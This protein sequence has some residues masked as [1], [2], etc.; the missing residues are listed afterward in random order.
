MYLY[1]LKN[2]GIL[3]QNI[4]YIMCDKLDNFLEI[5]EYYNWIINAENV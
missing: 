5:L 2:K 3:H 4:T 1:A